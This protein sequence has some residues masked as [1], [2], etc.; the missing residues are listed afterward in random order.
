M[1]TTSPWA[2]SRQAASLVDVG[3]PVTLVE[4]SCFSLSGRTGD[5]DPAF[6]QGLFFLDTRVISF[7]RLLVDGRPLEPLAVANEAPFEATFLGRAHRDERHHESDLVVFRRRHV[8]SGM[9]EQVTIH[10]HGSAPATI[11]L[12]LAAGTDFA[13]LFA[14]KELRAESPTEMHTGCTD[15]R[16]WFAHDAERGRLEVSVALSTDAVT[17][18][19][20]ARWDVAI[21][22]K[23]SFELCIEVSLSVDGQR[24]APRFRCGEA[25]QDAEPLQRLAQWRA[26]APRLHSDHP[27]L[28]RAVAQAVED[29]G[30]LRIFDPEH[31]ESPVIAAGAP[32]FMTLF[33]RDSLL[34]SWMSLLVD[35]TLAVGVLETL[36][37]LQGTSTVSETEEEPG[38]I[39]HE[40]RFGQ[41]SSLALGG[42]S[43]YYG[44]A[45]ATPLFVMLLGEVRRWGLAD[46]VV[47]R[48]LP[49]ADRALAWI[50]EC[51]DADGDGYVEYHRKTD[52]G[53][54]NQGWKDSWDGI[55]YAD[56]RLP[57]APIALCEVQAYT[58]GAYLARAYFALEADDQTTFERYRDRA[59]ALKAAFNKDFWLEDRGWFAVGLDADKEPID[60]LASNM[61]HCLWTGIVDEDKA[62]AVA[63]HLLSREMFSGWGIRT[64][65]TTM[66]RYNPVSYH[67][68]SVWPHDNAIIAAGL[69]RY[70]YVDHAHRVIEALLDTAAALGGRLPELFAG[71][72]REELAVPASYPASCAPQAWAAASPL[73]LL[74]SLLR[75]DPWVRRGRVHVAP[76]LAPRI[77]RL[78]LRDVALGDRRITVRVDG[79][80][81]EVDGLA[82]LARD[83][84]PRPALSRALGTGDVEA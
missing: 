37:R 40:V 68:G 54:A 71:F 53:L 1:T 69:M 84:Q 6:P 22:A 66:P 65:A 83:E 52:A 50:E 38:K 39:L 19:G 75:F 30:A 10:N 59:T 5:I 29:L 61:G 13:D 78:E 15:D 58:Y 36:A 20:T 11:A 48:L 9:R 81:T 14:V 47:Q 23:G 63:D 31:P 80:S 45:D 7:W 82:D 16:L 60:S 21:P 74:R 17:G 70:G 64:L 43:I 4:G 34:T 27:G 62:A 73:L 8:G 33:G 79:T 12:E 44:S 76:V 32:W 77:S 18:P 67:N 49:H 41:S 72:D 56:G 51:G 57:E 42:G 55:S 25:E 35:P 3:S 28:D 46:E 26:H 2:P 24:V